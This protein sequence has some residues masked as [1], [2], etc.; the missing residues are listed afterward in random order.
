VGA[1]RQGDYARTHTRGVFENSC[2]VKK[3]FGGGRF[4]KFLEN[5]EK[6]GE[7]H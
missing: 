6:F 3:T 4:C 1:A 7:V 5:S 2:G